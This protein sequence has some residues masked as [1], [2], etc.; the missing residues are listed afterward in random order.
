[1]VSIYGIVIDKGKLIML[2][3]VVRLFCMALGAVIVIAIIPF[4][5]VF[6]LQVICAMFVLYLMWF[7]IWL[8]K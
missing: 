1:M 4:I 7:I 5:I 3:Y 2:D 6:I 8:F